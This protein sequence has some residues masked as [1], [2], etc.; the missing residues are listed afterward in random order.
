MNELNKAELRRLAEDTQGWQNL[1]ECWPADQEFS[2]ADWEV[3]ALDEDDN[4]YPVIS[5]NTQQYDCEDGAEKLARF[6]AAA[7]PAAVLSLLDECDRLQATCEGLDR[8]NDAIAEEIGKVAAE[9]D[10][11]LAGLASHRASRMAYAS[12][13]APDAEG[14]HDVGSIHENIRK[15]KAELEAYKTQLRALIHISDATGWERHSCGEIAK[16]R[17]LLEQSK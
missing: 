5:V 8:Q 9:R 13:F 6:I 12:E 4:R 17:K 16:A 14:D 2:D 1:K 15:L 10:A 3:G 7:N 11:A